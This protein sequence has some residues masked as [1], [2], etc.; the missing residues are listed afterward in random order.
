M[1][2]T[3][4]FMFFFFQAEDGIRDG[5][6]TGVQTCALPIWFA[7]VTVTFGSEPGADV[8]L[9]VGNSADRSKQNLDSMTTVATRNDPTGTVTFP[10]TSTVTGRFLVVWFSRLPP[11]PG[12]S[13]K[14]EAQIFNVSVRGTPAGS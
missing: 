1:C 4:N 6:V 2:D 5:T 12:S 13:G 8:K 3:L 14:F 7:S 9:L 11:Q 10:I